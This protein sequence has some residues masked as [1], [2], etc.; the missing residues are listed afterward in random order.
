MH[1]ASLLYGCKLAVPRASFGAGEFYLT[2]SE[3]ERWLRSRALVG[4]YSMRMT[5]ALISSAAD[6]DAEKRG[7]P[8]AAHYGKSIWSYYPS[9]EVSFELAEK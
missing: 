5:A 3:V 2:S 8:H 7:K 1:R 4:K 9:G 6:S